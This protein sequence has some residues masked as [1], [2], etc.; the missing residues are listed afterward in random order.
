MPESYIR[1]GRLSRILGLSC[2]QGEV[3]P[4]SEQLF[5]MA[6]NPVGSEF[7]QALSSSSQEEGDSQS[8]Q[9]VSQ[10]QKGLSA[11]PR[12]SLGLPS[13]RFGDRPVAESETEGY[14]QSVAESGKYQSQGQGVS[15]PP[16][17]EEA[18]PALVDCQ[19]PVQ[20]SPPSISS[21]GVG[22]PH[23][24][25]PKRVGRIFS[26]PRSTGDLVPHVPPVPYK[27]SGGHGG[28]PYLEEASSPQEDSHK[29]GS[30]QRH[31][32]P[33]HKQGRFKIEQD[34]PG[35]DCTFLLGLQEQV[36]PIC[37]P[38]CRGPE[39]RSRFSL[40]DN[41]PRVG[42]VPR[43]GLVQ[44]DLPTSSGSGGRFVRNQSQQQAPSLRSSQPGPSSSFHR[45]N[46]IG[47]EQ[48][49]GD[50]SVP[51]SEL[52]VKGPSQT[53]DVQGSSSS[54]GSLLA[55]EQLV[56]SSTRTETSPHPNP[57]SET[58]TSSTNSDCVSF[59]KNPKCPG[60]VDFM[61]FAAQRDANV[62]PVNT[63]FLE[64]DKRAST[65]RQYDSAIKK[66]A[67]F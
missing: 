31:G 44:L 27:C 36:A 4:G 50:L 2:K 41:S 34:Q 18:T 62:D 54:S 59:L 28:L 1:G 19:E 57:Q 52:V 37:H 56:S 9:T 55:K 46:V 33:L 23:R 8:N 20:V 17:L 26:T 32:S 45:R 10:I 60:F 61:K 43:Q 15:D 6:R 40:Q 51:S 64:S 21:S 3:P 38:S 39:R 63:M 35:N 5:S 14:Q 49:E 7:S 65:L 25:L 66:L 13:V 67:L 47:L 58:N 22:Y 42:V 30:G 48:V 12:T 24:R 16:H 53:E 11:D 29:T